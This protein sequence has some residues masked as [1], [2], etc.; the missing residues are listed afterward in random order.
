MYLWVK[1]AL[2]K[3]I[4]PLTI[5]SLI[6]LLQSCYKEMVYDEN[7]FLVRKRVLSFENLVSSNNSLFIGDTVTINAKASGDSL[8]YDWY[9]ES[10]KLITS[11]SQ[12][13][14]TSDTSG[15]YTIACVI[16]D[17][18]GNS[19]RKEIHIQ[20]ST[21][22][23][24]G[25]LVANDLLIPLN[26]TMQLTALASGEQVTYN[27][28]SDAGTLMWD[29]N[30][31]LFYADA[32]GSYTVNCSATDKYGVTLNQSAVV[33]VI[34]G[35]VYKSLSAD[36]P[37]IKA[38]DFTEVTADVLGDDLTYSWKSYPPGNI[39]GEGYKILFTICHAD[40]FEISCQITDRDG[41]QEVKTISV[42]VIN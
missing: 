41:N 28:W 32:P 15:I 6:F 13:F 1:L 36:P 2:M 24:F 9:T 16:T 20:V 10:G 39:V 3:R 22:L 17:K 12:A 7:P 25:A 33:S 42:N 31:A 30:T 38:G 34:S 21:E 26:H 14:F 27:W 29:G 37:E 8:R 23:I 35:F 5:F 4:I 19:D 11:K 18:Y 40:V